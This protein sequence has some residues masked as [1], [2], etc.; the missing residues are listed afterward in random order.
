MSKQISPLLPNEDIKK[1]QTPLGVN[2]L[3]DMTD[4]EYKHFST[5]LLD[6]SGET[7]AELTSNVR[8]VSLKNLQLPASVDWREK[9]YVT[10][11]KDQGKTFLFS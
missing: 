9:G 3:S 2:E 6:E 4:E 5:G 11:V 1:Y 7:S 10:E 8:N